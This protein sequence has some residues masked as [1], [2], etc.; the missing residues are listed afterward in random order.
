M[1]KRFHQSIHYSRL[2]FPPFFIKPGSH[3]MAEILLKVMTNIYN[4]DPNPSLNPIYSCVT[5]S[6]AL[7]TS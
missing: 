4:R 3:Y 1:V 7:L 6:Y 5:R 2:D